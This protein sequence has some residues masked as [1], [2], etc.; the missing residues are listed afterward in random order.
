M[1]RPRPPALQA[2][3][4]STALLSESFQRL[5]T[6]GDRLVTA[7]GLLTMQWIEQQVRGLAVQGMPQEPAGLS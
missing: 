4:R 7:C 5:L 1:A 3:A 2:G 6:D